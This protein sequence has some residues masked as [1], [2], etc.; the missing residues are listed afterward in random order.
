MTINI[1]DI[2]KSL[3]GRNLY[4]KHETVYKFSHTTLSEK[5]FIAIHSTV[6]GPA[7]GGCRYFYYEDEQQALD[8]VLKLSNAMTYKTAM[9]NLPLGGAKA[10]IM[11]DPNTKKSPELM[12]FFAEC[13]EACKGQYYS[14][15]DV[16]ITSDD[17]DEVLKHTKYSLGS[18][19]ESGD[20]SYM[21]ALGTFMGIKTAWN[22]KTGSKSL[23]DVKIAVQGLGAVGY[24]LCEMLYKAGAFLYVSDIDQT[25]VN[26]VIINCRAVQLI[27]DDIKYTNAEIFAPCA[28]GGIIDDTFISNYKSNLKIIAGCA[29]NQ[30]ASRDVGDYLRNNGIIYAP[31][32]VINAGGVINVA[33]EL[34]DNR[35]SKISVLERLK[36]IPENLNFI[37][38][39]ADTMWASTDK[40]ADIMAMSR[41]KH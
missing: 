9:A 4:N 12:E 37:F 7:V 19:S 17:I 25:K 13:L 40:V 30:L 5:I 15:E 28:M 18:S 34:M 3:I 31:D 41:I 6:R 26:E 21:T 8:D 11:K 35:Y 22:Y 14:G 10:V 16:G 29:N 27:H 38:D 2:T 24:K 1:S 20:P 23:R 33:S 36:V 39:I 32:Y